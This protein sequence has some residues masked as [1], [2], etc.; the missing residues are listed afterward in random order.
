V[1]DLEKEVD[2]M[3]MDLSTLAK[4]DE[5]MKKIKPNNWKLALKQREQDHE[6]EDRQKAQGQ[7][8]LL[9]TVRSVSTFRDKKLPTMSSL[10]QKGILP[11]IFSPDAKGDSAEASISPYLSAVR[12]SQV[13][14]KY[15]HPSKVV[16]GGLSPIE[17]VRELEQ[18][19]H[20]KAVAKKEKDKGAF[21]SKTKA[22]FDDLG[23]RVLLQSKKDRAVEK[24]TSSLLELFNKQAEVSAESGTEA[25]DAEA[26]ALQ[27]ELRTRRRERRRRQVR[28]GKD[29]DEEGDYQVQAA[30]G[31]PSRSNLPIAGSYGS[32]LS[33]DLEG[34]SDDFYESGAGG[35]TSGLSDSGKKSPVALPRLNIEAVR[36]GGSPKGIKPALPFKGASPPPPDEAPPARLTTDA[37]TALASSPVQLN[38][39]TATA[40]NTPGVLIRQVRN[41][42]QRAGNRMRLGPQDGVVRPKGA[43][44]AAGSA[45]AESGDYNLTEDEA[46]AGAGKK[47]ALANLFSTAADSRR[48]AFGFDIL[49]KSL[50]SDSG[51]STL[52]KRSRK[53]KIK[54]KSIRDEN[55]D[56]PGPGAAG[57]TQDDKI[58]QATELEE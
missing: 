57:D 24:A 52:R 5:D 45:A 53:R 49:N 2:T 39:H 29:E 21:S 23:R 42:R 34:A 8:G 37:L 13:H 3:A 36:S 43:L 54:T 30:G 48:D 18:Q 47:E 25:S 27:T 17:T 9:D 58:K 14:R 44:M 56:S 50:G 19:W 7:K 10:V 38:G 51:D 46:E 41:N 4:L 33:I 6:E 55:R 28:L 40:E 26:H 22:G 32:P 11:D 31:G 12:D 20:S 15:L 35:G 16:P 1:L